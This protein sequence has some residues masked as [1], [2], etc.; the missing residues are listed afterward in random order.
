MV[1]FCTLIGPYLNF[2]VTKKCSSIL[3]SYVNFKNNIFQEVKDLYKGIIKLIDSGDK[4]KVDQ[5]H[6][7]TVIPGLGKLHFV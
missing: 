6:L 7:E 4:L 1:L 2:L 3:K 5:S